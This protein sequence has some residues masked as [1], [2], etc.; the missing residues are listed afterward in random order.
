MRRNSN[1]LAHIITT[2]Q[3]LTDKLA[4]KKQHVI[5]TSKGDIQSPGGKKKCVNNCKKGKMKMRDDL[6]RLSSE[7]YDSPGS[8]CKHR[9]QSAYIHT[10]HN[11]TVS[12]NEFCIGHIMYSKFTVT[13]NMEDILLE[14][15]FKV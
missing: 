1:Q 4:N 12:L 9:N 7:E 10:V 13:T 6:V 2:V 15:I 3:E 11:I 5:Y 14:A 8:D